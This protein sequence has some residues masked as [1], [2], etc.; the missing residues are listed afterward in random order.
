MFRGGRDG[1]PTPH[2]TFSIAIGLRTNR[3]HF[4]STSVWETGDPRARSNTGWLGRYFDHECAG[5]DPTVGISLKKTQPE[6]FGAMK[7][8]GI[9]L[10]SPELYRWMH[11]GGEEE[12]AE[13]L[14]G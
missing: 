11:G 8:P 12:M 13:D 2:K 3:S 5:M 6:A 4:V 7:N 10:S 14:F 9:C 1:S